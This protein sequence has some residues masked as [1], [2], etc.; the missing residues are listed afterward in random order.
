V[1]FV[2]RPPG[3]TESLWLAGVGLLG[4]MAV[5]VAGLLARRSRGVSPAAVP[6]ADA[7]L[8]D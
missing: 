6:A 1:K 8:A 4:C 7:K 5:A 2:F 3:W